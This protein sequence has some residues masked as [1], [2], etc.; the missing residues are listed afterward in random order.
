MA[1]LVQIN[2]VVG[3]PSDPLVILQRT[4]TVPITGAD[5]ET[6]LLNTIAHADRALANIRDEMNAQLNGVLERVRGS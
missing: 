2:L 6:V 5:P 1:N 4:Q 3:E